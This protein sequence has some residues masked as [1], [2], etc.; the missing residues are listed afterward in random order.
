VVWP[1]STEDLG[2][3]VTEK[4]ENGVVVALGEI[5]A[6]DWGYTAVRNYSFTVHIQF[7]RMGQRQREFWISINSLG[8]GVHTPLWFMVPFIATVVRLAIYG[9]G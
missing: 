1:R 9:H 5:G 8:G 7:G 6:G 4:G 2:S 3:S